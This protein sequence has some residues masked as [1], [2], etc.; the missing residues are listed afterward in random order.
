VT[1]YREL[2]AARPSERANEL[3]F[4]AWAMLAAFGTYFCM[5]GFRKPFT[6]ASFTDTVLMGLPF[7]TVLV[8]H[9]SPATWCRS[10]S[11]SK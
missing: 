1:E 2:D 7:K 3:W 6:A 9:R 10:S 8:H 4:A 5:Y 11:A